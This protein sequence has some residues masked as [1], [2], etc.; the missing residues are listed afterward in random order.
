[1]RTRNETSTPVK[2]ATMKISDATFKSIANAL[3][4]WGE[5][6]SSTLSVLG[7]RGIDR[8]WELADG[9]GR[10]TLG[11]LRSRGLTRDWSHVRDSSD[12]ALSR[13]VGFL[14][15]KGVVR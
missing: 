10:M 12:E 1:M 5:G 2:E 14:S 13:I 11:T 4:P 7:D 9:Y 8:C 3:C 15:R 6:Y